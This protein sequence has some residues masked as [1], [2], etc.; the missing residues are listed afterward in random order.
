MFWDVPIRS[1]SLVGL[2]MYICFGILYVVAA[3]SACVYIVGAFPHVMIA[4]PAY[5]RCYLLRVVTPQ[6]TGCCD[7]Y[8]YVTVLR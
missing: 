6:E 8:I 7:M 5:V 1:G 4:L 3:L 2:R